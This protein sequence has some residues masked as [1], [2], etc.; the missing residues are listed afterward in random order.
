MNFAQKH[1]ILSTA[2]SVPY[3][4]SAMPIE[5]M[6]EGKKY[7]NTLVNPK[8]TNVVAG[9]MPQEEF[10]SKF[11]RDP[12]D[13]TRMQTG[14]KTQQK[15]DPS[16]LA[17]NQNS[18]KQLWQNRTKHFGQYIKK[19]P[20]KF[21]SGMGMLGLNAAMTGHSLYGAGRLLGKMVPD[22]IKEK[23]DNK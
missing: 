16:K 11:I 7:Y 17:P 14:Y 22:K 6:M 21:M 2:L 18:F 15:I 4:L 3:G 9:A 20:G 12:D 19:H 10:D 1:P 5:M 23:F 8:E 13:V